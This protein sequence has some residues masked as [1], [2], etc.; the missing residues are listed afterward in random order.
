[1]TQYLEQLDYIAIG[2][3]ILLMA[4]IGLSFGWF[5]KD[6]NTYFKGNG[7][8]PWILASITSF[9]SLFSTF[10]F[11]AYAGIAYKDGLVAVTVFWA[12]VPACIIGGSLFAKRWRRTGHTT[13]MQYIEQRYS[14]PVQQTITWI[15]LIMRFLDNMVRIYALGIFIVI[16]TPVSL[17]W[18]IILSG[19]VFTTFNII[20]GLWSVVVMSIV[21]F[22]ILV[23]IVLI[24]LS[25]SLLEVGGIEGLYE[26][27]PEH[28][29]WFNGE[30]GS[31]FWLAVFYIVTL[32]N[33]NQK[34]T[35][36]QKFYCVRDEKAAI[37]V[38]IFAGIL[39]FVF[40]PFFL[41]PAVASNVILPDISNPEM[42]YVLLSKHLLPA[43]LMGILFASM[44]ATTMSTLNGEFNIMSGVLTN[45][46]YKKLI[47]PN[48]TDKH[49]LRVARFNVILIG[50]LV[51]IGGIC[52]QNFGGA[53]EANKLFTSI[54][55]IP[56]G[57]PLLFGILFKRPNSLSAVLTIVFG[58]LSGLILNTVSTLPWEWCTLIE[59][60]ICLVL[61][62]VPGYVCRHK[63][64]KQKNIEAFF[65][66]LKTPVK[67]VDKPQI[68]SQY[69]KTITRIF[70]FSLFFAGALFIII[71]LFSIQTKGG[72]LSFVTGV[73]CLTGAICWWAC[74]RNHIKKNS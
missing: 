11:I 72:R 62:F 71:S 31:F 19:I 63:A 41:L 61:Y 13:P 58:T 25:L 57:I 54:L 9:F 38:G 66:V 64:K 18:A 24:L 7:A 69:K 52:I 53:F 60:I 4:I 26:K 40:T 50:T 12:T 20:G 14:L 67:E 39:F 8:I 74:Y 5:V 48:A 17:E 1:M 35:F 46:V 51:I 15:S 29:S 22:V 28:M 33:Y 10:F 47:N 70:I 36:I 21:Q 45:D 23:L 30:K 27:I 44:F 2:V 59:I 68:D 65:L 56:I 49:L 16:V 32:F 42:S 43:G 73:L 55:A 37:K 6:T 3:Y 34:W